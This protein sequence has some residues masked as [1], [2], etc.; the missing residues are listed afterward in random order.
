MYE[1]E[2]EPEPEPVMY[3]PEPEPEPEPVVAAVEEILEPE[4]RFGFLLF[5]EDDP[6]CRRITVAALRRAGYHV[7]TVTNGLDAVNAVAEHDYD[8]V[9]MDV[10]L[11]VMTGLEAT[12]AIRANGRNAEV[13][14]IA[15]SA[16][17]TEADQT[18]ALASGMDAFVHKPL[19][20]DPLLS[21]LD[22]W[23]REHST[24]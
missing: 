20:L 19:D 12:A 10:Q 14:I 1:P 17:T 6:L 9:L 3:E 21:V 15:I 23:M 11:P 7:D 24:V 8:L 4:E 22:R 2:P 5:A 16:F 18:A 13:P